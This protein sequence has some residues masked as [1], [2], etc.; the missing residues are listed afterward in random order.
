MR[1]I[2]VIGIGAGNPDHMTVQAIAALNRAEVLFFLDKGEQAADLIRLREEICT[3][4]IEKPGYR[5]VRADSPKRDAARQDYRAGVTEWHDARAELY[6][7][8]MADELGEDGVGAFLVWGDP[9]L[10]DSTLR[11]LDQVHAADT[12]PFEVEV[13]P[14]VSALHALTAAHRIPLNAIGE[15]VLVT[16]G[17][18]LAEGFPEDFSTIAVLLD[19]GTGLASVLERE[20]EIHWGAYLGTPDQ[21]LRAGPVQEIGGAILEDRRAARL[22]KGWIMDTYLLRRRLPI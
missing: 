14:G 20:L 10:Y 8:L 16:T 4:F 22:R 21:M 5:I 11:I 3:R 7:R 1:T 17:R 15:P 2:L 12:V 19:D 18:R 6:A 13:I 9:S